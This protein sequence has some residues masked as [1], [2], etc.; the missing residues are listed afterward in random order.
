MKTSISAVSDQ[1]LAYK[2]YLNM[3]VLV[4]KEIRQFPVNVS[5]VPSNRKLLVQFLCLLDQSLNLH[6]SLFHCLVQLVT[7]LPE[8]TDLV[9]F[10]FNFEF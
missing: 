7:V 2:E 9:C 4:E 5:S 1:R 6:V 8:I 10:T 3:V